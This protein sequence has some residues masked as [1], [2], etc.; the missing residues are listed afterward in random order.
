[1]LCCWGMR[2]SGAC[3]Q[4]VMAS[5]TRLFTWLSR[6]SE[7]R[8]FQRKRRQQRR[9]SGARALGRNLHHRFARPHPIAHRLA[10]NLAT[11]LTHGVDDQRPHHAEQWAASATVDTVTRASLEAIHDGHH[12]SGVRTQFVTIGRI[13][14]KEIAPLLEQRAAIDNVA[15]PDQMR[16]ALAKD[17]IGLADP[18][19]GFGV[20]GADCRADDNKM[21]ST[22]AVQSGER[23]TGRAPRHPFAH[24][25]RD[26]NA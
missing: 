14:A 18:L 19:P 25:S 6:A 23:T 26:A 13:N 22:R 20:L 8:D 24:E 16:T 12:K 21:C 3:L 17:S 5:T 7:C 9:V 1:M 15:D 10:S 4:G 2:L 11:G